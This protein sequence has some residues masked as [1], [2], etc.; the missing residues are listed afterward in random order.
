MRS[1][2][3]T[4]DSDAA[5]GDRRP[6]R[7]GRRRADRGHRP[8]PRTATGSCGSA[9]C[10]TTSGS[11]C[12][13]GRRRWCSPRVYEGFGLPPLDAM[14]TGHPV[15]AT[16]AGAMP[17]V[18]GDAAAARAAGRRRRAGRRHRRGARPTP[19]WPSDLR[20]RGRER[21]ARF[22]W[23][24]TADRLVAL[25]RPPRPDLAGRRCA[26]VRS[27]AYA[28]ARFG[29]GGSRQMKSLVTGA[30]GFV[31][32]HLVAHLEA[33]GDDDRR[34]STARTGPTCSTPTALDP[35]PRGRAARR[36]VPPRPGGATSAD[37]GASRS[38]A[39][40]ANAEGTLNVLAG[41]PGRRRRPR[42]LSVSSADVYGK[43]S[44]E[45]APDRRGR[46][47]A[48][49]DA[50]TR[51]ARSP[52][53]TSGCRPTSATA[54]TCV[55][56]RAF[57]HLGPGQTNRFV[58]PAI[59]ERIAVNELD[60]GEVVPVGNL[61]PR[62]DFTDVR[63]V[64]RA[65]RLL[66]EHGEPARPTTCAPATTSPSASWPTGCVAMAAAP[67][68]PRGATRTCSAR[69]TMP[70]LR[71]DSTKLHKATGWIPEI[72]LEQTLADLLAEWRDPGRRLSALGSAAALVG[73][74]RRRPPLRV[75]HRVA[76]AGVVR[77]SARKPRRRLATASST[78]LGLPGRQV[79]EPA[80]VVRR[81]GR[82]AA[83]PRCS[84]RR[85]PAA[86]R[87]WP[88]GSRCPPPA[89]AARP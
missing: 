38:A 49:G 22:A 43:V 69:S 77:L 30:A 87:P 81:A 39:F 50:R 66:I 88:R 14:A 82:A 83:R 1:A 56:V 32:R 35:L 47:P 23:D 62:R 57:N 61:T 16:A 3:S 24:D 70:V 71:G 4:A 60:G 31:G 9:G 79:L 29:R 41:V 40:R 58:A 85:P 21:V 86:D 20:R 59:A 37:R 68:A 44:L 25:Y 7:L 52:P 51:P 64:V 55:R 34:A 53:T 67:D 54:S 45:R 10:P 17:E 13:G 42:V 6:R 33:C 73:E 65:Y 74:P 8:Q 2:G 27:S 19:I 48:A 72:A 63:D 11:R 26:R 89:R 75:G 36:R 46:A 15:V 78:A 12:C 5:P 84:G 76:L 80:Q 28:G 18:V